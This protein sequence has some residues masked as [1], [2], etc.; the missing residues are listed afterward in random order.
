MSIQAAKANS[1]AN[2]KQKLPGLTSV[3]RGYNTSFQKSSSRQRDASK[4]ILFPTDKKLKRHR[5]ITENENQLLQICPQFLVSTENARQEREPTKLTKTRIGDVSAILP[6]LHK[7]F[8]EPLDM[9][10]LFRFHSKHKFWENISTGCC[11]EKDFETDYDL[12]RLYPIR[13]D[14]QQNGLRRKTLIFTPTLFSSI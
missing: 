8:A 7:P 9:S 13:H 6:P 4:T 12:A 1:A 11:T 3:C 2:W 5:T 10:N 14:I